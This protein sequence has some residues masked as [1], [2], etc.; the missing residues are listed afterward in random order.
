[1]PKVDFATE[2]KWLDCSRDIPDIQMRATSVNAGEVAGSPDQNGEEF[3]VQGRRIKVFFS[4]SALSWF[5]ELRGPELSP[6]LYIA[7]WF[8]FMSADEARS[9]ANKLGP[10]SRDNETD[11]AQEM[12]IHRSFG[13][14]IRDNQRSPA[15]A[16][17]KV[18]IV[19]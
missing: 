19:T 9:T 14:Q 12:K 16:P 17:R 3:V 13:T 6:G 4:G 7:Y 5:L 15:S 11:P 10:I 8:K 2:A 18:G 1:M